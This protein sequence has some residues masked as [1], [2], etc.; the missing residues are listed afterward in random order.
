MRARHT[1]STE[2][3]RLAQLQA[4]VVRSDQ[5]LERG[6]SR[7]AVRR[8]LAQGQWRRLG[9]SVYHTAPGEVGW[10]ALAWAGVLLGGENARLGPRA[11]GFL[12]GLV[13]EPPRPIDVLVPSDRRVQVTGP[14]VFQRERP[15]VRSPGSVA[16]PRRLKVED[17]VLDLCAAATPGGV[18]ALVTT[19][20]QRRLTTPS[21][22]LA[23]LEQRHRYRHRT[24]LMN[25]LRDVA[26]GAESPL[27][28]AYL[29]G[30]EQRHGLPRG[31]RQVSH[32]GLPYYSDVAYERYLVLV[33]LDGRDGHLGVGRFRDMER[34]NRFV[35]RHYV[36][37]RYGWFDVLE[38]PCQVASQVAAALVDRGWESSL[39]RCPRC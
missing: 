16:S 2:L 38:K 6:L 11:S 12:H 26:Q 1:P 15:G 4:G 39:R 32:A 8:L 17:T 18:V 35:L 22:L 24:L 13:S 27:E 20:V 28:V 33:E 3:D 14:W 10:E 23:V 19:S 9:Q 37:L 34:D 36:T 31:D 30:V 7:H 5:V 29:R 25:L 21:R